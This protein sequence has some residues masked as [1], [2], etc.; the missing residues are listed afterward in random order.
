MT[1]F[2][3][4]LFRLALLAHP[5]S[6]RERYGAEMRATFHAAV[7]ERRRKGRWA[8]TW[9]T[10]RASAD[11]ARSGW[12][13]R[14]KGGMAMGEWPTD[15]RVAARAL[16][17]TPWFTAAAVLVLA[18]GIG[19]NA[20]VFSALKATLLTPPPY[21][22]PD[23][24][25]LLDLTEASHGNA[26]RTFPWSYRK[27]EVL[28]E[29]RDMPLEASAAYASRQVTLTGTGDAT[30]LTAELVTPHYLKVLGL[31]PVLGRDFTATD[32]VDGAAPVALLGYGLWQERFGADR[33][34]V[35]RSVTLNG[36]AVTVVGV[37]PAGFRGLTGGARLFVPVHTGAVLFSPVLVNGTQAHWL[38]AVGRLA[39][40]TTLAALRQRMQA[41]GKSVVETYP[42]FDPTVVQGAS[43]QSFLS[44]RV[45]DQ[46]KRSVLILS[47]A[48]ALLLLVACANLAGL[49]LAR[50]SGRTREAAV[51]VAM[52]AGRWRVA[53]GFLVEAMLLAVGG[54]AAALVVARF[55]AR[56]LAAAWP[57]RF[58]NGSWDVRGVDLSA[59][60]VDGR[61]IAFAAL[62]TLV[63]GLVFGALPALRVS[64]VSPSRELRS[65]TAGERHAPRGPDLRGTLV[66]A[67]IALAL[68]LLVGAGLL[69]RSLRELQSVERGFRPGN[70]VTFSFDIPRTS[71]W[72]DD[73]AGF[74][75]RYLEK[76]T[77]LPDVES[78]AV[79]C[80]APLEGHCWITEVRRAGDR[81]WS[82]GSR[83][84]IGVNQ[85][86]DDVFSTLG[87]PL[88]QGRTFTSEDQKGS[89]PVVVLSE[90]AVR[91]LFPDGHALGQPV[92][93]GID[94]TPEVGSGVQGTGG[95]GATAEVIGVV[96]DVLYDRP[97]NGVMPEAY[98]E[99]RQE[100]GSSS[101]IVR[102]R[103]EPL[104]VI[105]GARAA[106]ATL[107]PDLPI[108]GVSTDSQWE[109]GA[110]ADTRVLGGLLGA[111]A[112]LALLLACTG[113]W[114]VVAYAVT[115]RTPELGLRVALGAEPGQVV[116]L[117]VRG[118][119]VLAVM[120]VLAGAVGAWGA[121]RVLASLLYDVAPTDPLTF[122]VAAALLL[123]VAALA[124]WVPAR[125][126]T[127]VDPMV[128]LR[129]E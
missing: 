12:R 35:G 42:P 84:S 65:G 19:A 32:D 121:A 74:N 103:G 55:G 41:V 49:L 111:F 104:A 29:T 7:R 40:G 128:A 16:R 51:R 76:L 43:A 58:L 10:V 113:V 108:Y 44:A 62:A 106:L 46:A 13:E 82:E 80:I 50:A 18:L 117:V 95:G 21:P 15:V 71:H 17:R 3:T 81:A 129:A 122:M 60:S 67:E 26:P 47:A 86:S 127:R 25:V 115:R 59:V 77:A 88:L 4:V 107:D 89:R 34:V 54:G 100:P 69:I 78:A 1:G 11:V 98:I 68:V 96:G 75:E 91:R 101:F 87:V 37:A 102:T 31:T 118:G 126:A 120:G 123:L 23:E 57:A 63:V 53:R 125:K 45:N 66:S 20:A 79:S 112:A 61:V 48:A 9:Y 36:H 97:E 99:E 124:A 83:P 94:L 14:R 8:A 30:Y 119:L 90:A 56:A 70:L 85:V 93:M 64:Q 22:H 38:R 39:P 72:S 110:T 116:A 2:A 114:G 92:A 33:G 5:P 6:L 52:G 73:V 24:L 27:Y 105:P 28:A 109:A